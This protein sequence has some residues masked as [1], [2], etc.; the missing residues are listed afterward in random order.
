[1]PVFDD[2]KALVRSAKVAKGVHQVVAA[3]DNASRLKA[4]SYLASLMASERGLSAKIGQMLA[5]K[6][7]GEVFTPLREGLEPTAPNIIRDLLAKAWGQPLESVLSVFDDQGIA[8]S[9]GQVHR[10]TL[11][12]GRE[13]AIKIRYPGIDQALQAETR[14]LGLLPALG[15]AKKWGLD[16]QGY[17]KVLVDALQGE[18]DYLREADDQICYRSQLPED[19]QVVVPEVL[20]D[21]CRENVLVQRWEGGF[22]LEEIKRFWDPARLRDT[23][24][25]LLRHFFERC[26]C[27]GVVHADPHDGNIRFRVGKN[28]QP[29]VVLYDF[30]CLTKVPK[31]QS[32]ALARLILEARRFGSADPL[33]LLAKLGFDAGKL[34]HI[35]QQLPA[36]VRIQFEPFIQDFSCD[37]NTWHPGERLR[38]VLGDLTWWFRSAGPA[39]LLYLLRAFE[40][41]IVQ[42][43]SLGVKLPWWKIFASA[44]GD[45]L[46]E[47]KA[48]P[49]PAT[50]GRTF[51]ALAQKLRIT[52][53]RKGVETV[54]LAMPARVVDDLA[55]V[56]DPEILERLEQSD[57][58][59][60]A[61]VLKIKRSGYEPGPVFE[62]KSPERLVRLWLE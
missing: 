25:I 39:D 18:L 40:G 59:L 43:R 41:L 27:G 47:A 60:D 21:L 10:G 37:L 36:V 1:M 30:G 48:M 55:Q 46:E 31:E 35:R 29:E 62:D 32:L 44:V 16:L 58:D 42:I 12:D 2:L 3:V 38:E 51:D 6:E 57:V 33:A 4:R 24:K 28:K 61:V 23:G 8:A 52:V 34:E 45:I 56:M 5:A 19:S 49:L 54:S 7:D 11:H 9:L 14:I 50:T 17:K 22:S 53:C 20:R 13:V 26:F 15:P